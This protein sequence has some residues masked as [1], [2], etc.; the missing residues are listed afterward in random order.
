MTH[1][2]FAAGLLAFAATTATAD[3][4]DQIKT[5]AGRALF[6]KECHRCHADTSTDPSYGPTLVGVIGRP[7]GSIEGYDYS[8]ALAVSGIVWTRPALRA[9]MADNTGFMPG[10]RMRH[11]GISD[12]TVQ[13]FILA[14]LASLD[15]E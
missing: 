10:T 8:E 6:D 15:T 7:A 2:L 5:D 4:F 14:Y 13:D 11:V 12:A 3:G 9:W 1:P